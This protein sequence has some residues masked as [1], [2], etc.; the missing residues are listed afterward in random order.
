VPDVGSDEPKRTVRCCMAVVL[1]LTVY[2][3]CV[4]GLTL[5]DS[6]DGVLS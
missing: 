2:R 6:G 1:C 3:V 4:S 5:N